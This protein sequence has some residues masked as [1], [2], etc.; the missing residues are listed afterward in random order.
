MP[1]KKELLEENDLLREKLEDV[2]DE[3]NE[4]LGDSEFEEED[5]NEKED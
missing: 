3:I 1:T 2:R 4:V 5:D